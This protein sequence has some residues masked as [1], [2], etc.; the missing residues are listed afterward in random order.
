MLERY[1][2]L[3]KIIDLDNSPTAGTRGPQENR[4]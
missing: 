1:R 4:R 3:A 2:E